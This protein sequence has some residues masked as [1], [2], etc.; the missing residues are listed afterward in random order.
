[1]ILHFYFNDDPEQKEHMIGCIRKYDKPYWIGYC[2]IPDGCEFYTAVEMTEAKV[3][4]GKSIKE[5]VQIMLGS[6]Y[7]STPIS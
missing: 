7:L 5:M 1:M 4:N 2:D 3:F 6:K